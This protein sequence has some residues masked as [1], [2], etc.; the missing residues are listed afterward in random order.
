LFFRW[1]KCFAHFAHLISE[2]RQGVLR[3]FY[4]AVI[5]VLWMVLHSG[6][7]P[8]KYAFSLLGVVV[9]GGATLEEI[10]PILAERERRA[11]LDRASL[12]RR[13]QNNPSQRAGCRL[14]R[15]SANAAA[16]AELIVTKFALRQRLRLNAAMK[17]LKPPKNHRPLATQK[18]PG[19][20]WDNP[21]VA[22]ARRSRTPLEQAQAVGNH[23][24]GHSRVGGD[25]RPQVSLTGK[26]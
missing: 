9:S 4:V 26:R 3:S 8:S 11:A 1:L 24:Q 19:H 15:A 12:A 25:R 5:G 16:C 7:K 14:G 13:K 6:A 17:K 2:S 18:N 10:A 20:D 22:P 23:Q 21:A